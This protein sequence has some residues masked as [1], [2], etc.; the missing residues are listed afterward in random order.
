[1]IVHLRSLDNS[2]AADQ[3]QASW[4]LA[5][6]LQFLAG[7]GLRKEMVVYEIYAQKE[8]HLHDSH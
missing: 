7:L 8:M 5:R 1:M 2:F 4:N 6:L 3:W